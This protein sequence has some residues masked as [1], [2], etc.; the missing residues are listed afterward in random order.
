[1]SDFRSSSERDQEITLHRSFCTRKTSTFVQ[2]SATSFGLLFLNFSQTYIK[3]MI[4]FTFLQIPQVP[5]KKSLFSQI[6]K[7]Q[8]TTK[9]LICLFSFNY[10]FIFGFWLITHYCLSPAQ[11]CF[12]AIDRVQASGDSSQDSVPLDSVPLNNASHVQ[13]GP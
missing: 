3:H 13:W 1:M 6:K 7:Q 9:C 5:L 8:Q 11:K 4:M 12:R 2:L 10:K